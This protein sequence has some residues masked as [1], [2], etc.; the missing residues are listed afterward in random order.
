MP[1]SQQRVYLHVGVPKSGTTYL[2]AILWHNRSALAGAGLLN[3]GHVPTAQFHAAVDLQPERY[4]TW[5]Q[6]SMLGAW[7]RLAEQIRAW[8]DTSIVSHEL[9]SSAAEPEVARALA[10][11]GDAEVH[12]VCTVRD[13]GRQLP[14]AWQENVKT[15][16]TM[17]FA[18]F[19]AAV[20]APD[21]PVAEEFWG[22]QDAARV[23]AVWGAALPPE[24]VH[25]VT[26]PQPGAAPG[27][28]W[29]RFAQV[30]G[31]GPDALDT[32]DTEV[33][34]SNRS[35]GLA[36]A[37]LLRRVNQALPESLPWTRYESLVKEQ[38]AEDI[39]LG[40]GN[41]ITVPEP[42]RPWVA[43]RAARLAEDIRAA[44]YEVVGDLAELLPV[45]VA[46]HRPPSTP[47]DAEVLQVAVD[48]V[49]E[50]VPRLP[51]QPADLP[52]ADRLKRA[53]I[54]LSERS[55]PVMSLRRIYW[56]TRD[57]N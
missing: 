35:L 44:G 27:L 6:P 12:I 45:V 53:L 52:R 1:A 4:S 21:G 26:V 24:R 3:P 55:A 49:A 2:Q 41:R 22:F 11:L 47:S 37:E 20:R 57:K 9:L 30:I 19:L 16:Q 5:I 10:S 32:I 38:I 54:T 51:A 40:R 28:L 34:N 33:P 13:L 46:E 14:S 42:D 50:L 15:R 7:D 23:L 56:K 48:L 8:P 17:S 43:D 18:E 36:E 39:L 25:V 31:L 29:R